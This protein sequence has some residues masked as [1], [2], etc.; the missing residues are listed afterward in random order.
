MQQEEACERCG[1]IVPR[2]ELSV[3]TES[4][5]NRVFSGLDAPAQTDPG[6]RPVFSYVHQ[7]PDESVL[8]DVTFEGGGATVL[9][10]V[11][12]HPAFAGFF[13][14]DPRCARRPG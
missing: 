3:W 8:A 10:R 4:E 12:G 14:L 9:A 6:D 7:D 13:G 1:R 5:R 2:A 11:K